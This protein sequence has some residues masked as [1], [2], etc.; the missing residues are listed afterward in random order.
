MTAC[1]IL[2]ALSIFAYTAIC[3]K[4]TTKYGVR[5]VMVSIYTIG[6]SSLPFITAIALFTGFIL[7]LQGYHTLLRFG[8][9]SLIGNAITITLV[10]ELAPVFTAIMLI[11]RAGSATTSHLAV[12]RITEQIQALYVSNI[13]PILFLIRPTL[14]AFLIAMPI[15]TLFFIAI[16]L[17]AG[18]YLATA[19]LTI[20]SGVYMQGVVESTS[21]LDIIYSMIKSAIFAILMGVI[22]TYIGYNVHTYIKDKGA[23][24]IRLATT[25]SVVIA[26][27][28][29]LIA[30]YI[31][32][33]FLF[34]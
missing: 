19:V 31:A 10:Q 25:T 1:R 26:C 29:I 3:T 32:T 8:A 6:A 20:P 9:Q 14:F 34:T 23:S 27:I 17:T 28:A 2:G 18:Y 7:A 24:A 13:P 15:L 4:N 12:M 16:A 11:A 30:N 5:R 22:T 21:F 33:S